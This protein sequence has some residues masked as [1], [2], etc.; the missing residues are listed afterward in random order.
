MHTRFKHLVQHLV[1][2]ESSSGACQLQTRPCD[3]SIWGC[4]LGS[5]GARLERAAVA[6]LTVVDGD[7][8][9]KGQLF[10]SSPREADLQAL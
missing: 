7:D 9:V 4:R 6:L 2:H 8:P 5:S 3:D 1:Q 10:A